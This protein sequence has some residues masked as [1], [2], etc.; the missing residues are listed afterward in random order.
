MFQP[1]YNAVLFTV[2]YPKLVGVL[3]IINVVVFAVVAVIAMTRQVFLSS[4]FGRL[5]CVNSALHPFPICPTD[6]L[7]SI[8]LSEPQ[9]TQR[10]HCIVRR[11]RCHL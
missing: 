1:G 11:I 4:P 6:R 9:S 2:H 8:G 5:C 7:H 10:G 3:V